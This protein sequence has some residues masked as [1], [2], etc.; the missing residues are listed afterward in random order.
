MKRTLARTHA[1]A[2]RAEI[3][4]KRGFPRTHAEEELTRIGGGIHVATVR[5]ETAVATEAERIGAGPH[6]PVEQCV[7]TRW[8]FVARLSDGRFALRIKPRVLRHLTATQAERV[9]ADLPEGVTLAREDE[10]L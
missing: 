8:A 9:V 4:A 6:T 7:T 2:I 5:T 10:D 3:D 1:E